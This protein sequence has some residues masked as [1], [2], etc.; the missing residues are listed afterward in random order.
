MSEWNAPGHGHHLAAWLALVSGAVV[1]LGRKGTRGH[2]RWGWLY[3]L[4]MTAMNLSSL[5]IYRLFGGFGVFHVLA[6]CSLL[7]L[8][9]AIVPVRTR[10][11]ARNW[12]R[13]HAT[14]ITWSYVGLVAAAASELMTR[15]PALGT[16]VRAGTGKLGLSGVDFG[17]IVGSTS[18]LVAVLGGILVAALLPRALAR[19]ASAA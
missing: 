5:A 12:A 13:A 6:I 10:K 17:L 19:L 11:P 2:R 15:I 9:A 16:W 1:L 8:L 14:L 18:V 3:L 7:T 4:S